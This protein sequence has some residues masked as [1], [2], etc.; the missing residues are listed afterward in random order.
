MTNIIE[1]FFILMVNNRKLGCNHN[2][3]LLLLV[4]L[5]FSVFTEY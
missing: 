5:Q 1:A 4:I 2:E 3:N